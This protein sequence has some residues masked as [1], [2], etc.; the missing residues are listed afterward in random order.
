MERNALKVLAADQN[1][2]ASSLNRGGEAEETE[3]EREER[4]RDV[5]WRYRL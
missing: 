4:D 3:R 2:W 5:K 1:N